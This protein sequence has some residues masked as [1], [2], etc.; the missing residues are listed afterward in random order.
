VLCTTLILNSPCLNLQQTECFTK[1]SVEDG[2]T[3]CV[4]TC[5]IR[6]HS[7]VDGFMG[8]RTV[9]HSLQ[10]LGFPGATDSCFEERSYYRSTDGT[11]HLSVLI[12]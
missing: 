12:I 10:E 7:T 3:R 11:V 2:T 1:L 9:T 6:P 8:S 4:K 5:K